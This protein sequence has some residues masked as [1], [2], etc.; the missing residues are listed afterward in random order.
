MLFLDHDLYGQIHVPSGDG[1]GWEV[2]KFIKDNFRY[3]PSKVFLHS[4]NEK[5]VKNMHDLLPWAKVAYFGLFKFDGEN[6][7]IR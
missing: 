6:V 2:A 7:I 3:A 1:T 5:G 4:H